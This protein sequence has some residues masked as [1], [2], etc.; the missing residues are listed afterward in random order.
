MRAILH[1]SQRPTGATRERA[2]LLEVVRAVGQSDTQADQP[3]RVVR[4]V[5]QAIQQVPGRDTEE[6]GRQAFLFA[7]L[8]VRL[9]PTRQSLPLG[10]RAGWPYESRRGA[11][12]ARG[13]SA[14]PL[15]LPRLPQPP[16]PRGA[17]HSAVQHS[18]R[19][20]LGRVQRGYALSRLPCGDSASGVSQR[21]TIQ[22]H[23]I[24]PS[25]GVS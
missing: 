5:R 11:M 4:D 1:G 8:L 9:Q 22:I 17:P 19:C 23:G 14:G 2:I 20:A 16:A 10:R 3:A 24:Y 18:P 13:A 21:T 6:P 12:A 15:L 25:G 7:R